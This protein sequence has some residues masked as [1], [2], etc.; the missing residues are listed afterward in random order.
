[1]KK[2]YTGKESA[3]KSLAMARE[4]IR[5]ANRNRRWLKKYDIHRPIFTNMGL[6]RSFKDEFPEQRIQYYHDIKRIIKKGVKGIDIFHDEISSDFS[7]EKRSA[8]PRDE[9]RWLRQCAKSGIHI[10]STAQEFH[11]IHVQFRRLVTEAWRCKK[12]VGCPRPGPNLPEVHFIWGVIGLRNTV[13][14]PYNELE[15]EYKGLPHFVFIRKRVTDIFD[16]NEFVPKVDKFEVEHLETNCEVCGKKITK[17][18]ER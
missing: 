3:G 6:S 7:A 5:V 17:H 4:I 12:L 9:G 14:S 13:I 18:R 8:L 16:T 11:D 2:V 15:P 10:Y 1:M